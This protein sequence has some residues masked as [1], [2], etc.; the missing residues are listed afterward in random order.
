MAIGPRLATVD[1]RCAEAKTPERTSNAFHDGN[2]NALRAAVDDPSVIPRTVACWTGSD[3]ASSTLSIRAT[4]SIRT[5]L[6][7]GDRRQPERSNRRWI[8]ALLAPLG[9]TR[10]VPGT[11]R[12]IGRFGLL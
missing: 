5:L 6:E 1:E 12:R 11:T 3:R 10:E 8:Q 4:G 2:V 7:I 9:G